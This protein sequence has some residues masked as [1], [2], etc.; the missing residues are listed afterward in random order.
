MRRVLTEYE[1]HLQ[2]RPNRVVVHKWSRFWDD[3][4]A[5]FDTAL[6][7]I[8]QTDYVALGSRDIRFFRTGEHPPVRGTMITLSRDN[9]LLYTRGYVPFLGA[10]LGPRVPR[11]IE[12]V[13]HSGGATMTQICQE[14]LALTKLDWNTADFGGKEPITTAFS[15]DV[16][17]I[18]A[19]L[20][21]TAPPPRTLYRFYM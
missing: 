19:E 21:S 1:R 13:E 9:A 20:P 12:I 8:P 10:H 2:H 5:G 11:P 16:G 17:Q 18:L 15:H 4:R 14:I 6:V 7:G 3:E